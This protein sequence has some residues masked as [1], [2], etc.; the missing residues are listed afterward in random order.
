MDFVVS[1]PDFALRINHQLTVA[2]TPRITA[3]QRNRSS[4]KPDLVARRYVGKKLLYGSFTPGFTQGDFVGIAT[5]EKAKIF[6]KAN[7]FCTKRYSLLD[8]GFGPYKVELEIRRRNHLDQCDINPI[9]CRDLFCG[10]RLR[11][12]NR[13][14]IARQGVG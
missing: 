9:V 2:N 3:L 14:G 11:S 1:R 12:G 10:F 5:S 4:S 8:Q 6:R 7:E 13:P